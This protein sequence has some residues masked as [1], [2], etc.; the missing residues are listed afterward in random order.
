MD[1]GLEQRAVLD[2]DQIVRDRGL[3]A[4][5]ARRLFRAAVGDLPGNRDLPLWEAA[6]VLLLFVVT[7]ERPETCRDA[8][9]EVVLDRRPA[10][11]RRRFADPQ[12]AVAQSP[13]GLADDGKT[14]RLTAPDF[15]W[16][17]DRSR[18]PEV[19]ALLDLIASADDLERCAGVVDVLDTL[20]RSLASPRDT[21]KVAT[22]ALA[23]LLG[24]WR[25]RHVVGNG[26]D[27]RLVALGRRLEAVGREAATGWIACD[28]LLD[29][30]RVSVGEGDRLTF[31]TAVSMGRALEL[32]ARD[33]RTVTNLARAIEWRPQDGEAEGDADR[34]GEESLLEA[35]D[36]I[37]ER[38]KFLTGV[39]R[40][41]L[42]RAFAN[43]PWHAS[44]PASTLRAAVRGDTQ[45]L[46]VEA[47]RRDRRVDVAT[48]M[49]EAEHYEAHVAR[50]R[51]VVDHLGRLLRIHVA[52]VHP[53]RLPAEE[54]ER[55]RKLLSALRRAGF[56]R[57][58]EELS[59][60]F[61][62]IGTDLFMI[63]AGASR[64]LAA[65]ERLHEARALS[66]REAHDDII[67]AEGFETL[68]GE[69]EAI[70]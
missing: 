6:H 21:V 49:A 52:L 34:E 46:L 29:F 37:P 65:V 48:V 40:G 50:W 44:H 8:F 68:Y 53:D 22:R 38:P 12:A 61:D 36:R 64:H 43:A 17:T 62:E 13:V 15:A 56:D 45:A 58:S 7:S 3:P 5:V 60:I 41:L 25:E 54:L 20:A 33:R 4:A 51:A 28:D 30:W 67:F 16:E 1:F 9:L 23:R 63:E 69:R 39:E 14:F 42:A 66:D 47:A 32:E 31:R 2:L 19:L 24:D 59:A 18:L 27:R 35:L 26:L 57:P 55:G 70:P 11:L 10:A